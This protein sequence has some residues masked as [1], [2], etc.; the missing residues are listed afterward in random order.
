MNKV[1]EM[2]CNISYDVWKDEVFYESERSMKRSLKTIIIS[3][4]SRT[5]KISLSFWIS[6]EWFHVLLIDIDYTIQ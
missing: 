5:L 3:V 6:F 2:W 1:F 4:G